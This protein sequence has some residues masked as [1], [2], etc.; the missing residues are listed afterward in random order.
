MMKEHMTNEMCGREDSSCL[1]AQGSLCS[2]LSCSA[3]GFAT[4]LL[5]CQIQLY[6]AYFVP[7]FN[8]G[9]GFGLTCLAVKFTDIWI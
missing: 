6:P 2:D 5:I 1:R 8:L 3:S 7:G 9:N 4:D